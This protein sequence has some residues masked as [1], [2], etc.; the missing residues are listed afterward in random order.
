VNRQ[1]HRRVLLPVLAGIVA[2]A[3]FAL[4]A[5]ARSPYGRY[6]EHGDWTVSGPAA[7]LCGWVPGG[8]VVVPLALSGAGWLLMI[9]A[10]MLPSTLPLFDVF[11][12]IAAARPDRGRLLWMLGLGYGA[13][14]ALFGLVAHGL[15]ALLLAAV[16]ASPLLAWHAGLFGAATLA[17]AGAFQFTALK[18]RCLEEC[19]TPTSFVMRHWHAGGGPAAAF[20]LG[21][22]HG[23][24]CV[25]CCWALMLLMFLVGAGSL[26]WML[27]LGAVMAIEKNFAW[28][29]HLGTPLGVVLI[30]GGVVLAFGQA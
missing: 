20:R 26:G 6:L 24:F 30:A 7:A 5:W 19:R 8:E 9:A 4:W 14:W 15:H 29:R 23:V 21:A 17:L 1:R 2:L 28:G 3:W 25:G 11:D 18:R 22:R 16:A 27:V 13:V 12:R 10:M